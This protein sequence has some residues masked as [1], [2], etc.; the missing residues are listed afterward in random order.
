M[1]GV[2]PLLRHLGQWV[3]GWMGETYDAH[4]G[5]LHDPGGVQVDLHV[6]DLAS[7]LFWGGEEVDGWVGGW[8][9][10]EVDWVDRWRV[11]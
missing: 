4:G 1:G 6:Q 11:D 8:M 2:S 7:S 5:A 10:R 9:R 3:G